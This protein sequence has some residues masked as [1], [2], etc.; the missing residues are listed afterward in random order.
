[1]LSGTRKGVASRA[2]GS[3]TCAQTSTCQGRRAV[4]SAAGAGQLTHRVTSSWCLTW[5]DVLMLGERTGLE[6]ILI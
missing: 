1:M 5:E 3:C 2:Q 6:K 4:G